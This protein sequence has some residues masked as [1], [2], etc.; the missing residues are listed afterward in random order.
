MNKFFEI[1]AAVELIV[2]R[3][4]ALAL[5]LLALAEFLRHAFGL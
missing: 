3:L 2:L 1:V 4:G 5:L